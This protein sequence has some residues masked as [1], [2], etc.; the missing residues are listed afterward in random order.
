M[1]KYVIGVDI[2]GRSIKFGLFTVDGELINKSNIPTRVEN[3]GQSI[4]P[5]L[6]DHLK[7]IIEK[8]ELNSE[9]LVGIGLGF[10]GP[11]LNKRIARIGANLGW[12]EPTHIVDYLESKLEYR[13]L[14]ENDANVA[15]LGELWKGAGAGVNNLVMV[16]LG[17]GV[18]GGVVI[19]GKIVSGSTG[20]GGEIGHMPFLENPISRNCG[21]SGS[22]CFELMTSATGLEYYASE[23]LFEHNE[24]SILRNIDDIDAKSIFDAAQNND[25][26][27][28]KIVD[29]YSHNLA[30][31]LA[32]ISAIVDPEIFVI[33]GGVS[34]AGDY[35]LDKIE[36]EYKKLAFPVTRDV[37]LSIAKLGNDAGIYGAAKLM[38]E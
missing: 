16:T 32:I 1:K 12:K 11:I 23:Y 14:V 34:N 6:A 5:D 21:C 10:P 2:G 29:D 26:L 19:D 18:G 28:E 25:K 15:A 13:F 8:F 31:G 17:T 9:N 37:K 30:R 33:G 22:R 3:D 24:P 7:K 35:L 36:R 27:A 38:L 20:S 4:L